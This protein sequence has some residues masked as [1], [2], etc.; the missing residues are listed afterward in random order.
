NCQS[1]PKLEVTMTPTPPLLE[2]LQ[3]IALGLALVNRRFAERLFVEVG[4]IA[5]PEGSAQRELYDLL[6]ILDIELKSTVGGASPHQLSRIMDVLGIRQR[7]GEFFPDGL[8]RTL[9]EEAEREWE[10]RQ[11]LSPFRQA[12]QQAEIIRRATS[13]MLGLARKETPAERQR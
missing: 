3:W 1:R 11:D 10:V 5:F 12:R 6:E 9:A 7:Q 2:A 4:R 13:R 8:L